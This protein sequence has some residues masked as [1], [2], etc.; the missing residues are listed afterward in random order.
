MRGVAWPA[1]F[2]ACSAALAAAGSPPLRAQAPEPPPEVAPTGNDPVRLPET[3]IGGGAAPTLDPPAP[4][5]Q[6][7]PQTPADAGLPSVY[8]D[9]GTLTTPSLEA[10]R[11]AIN[12]ETGGANIVELPVLLEGKVS[13]LEDVLK[14]T[15]GVWVTSQNGGDDVQLSIRGSGLGNRTF[16][17]GVNGYI[18]GFM[19]AGRVDAGLQNQLVNQLANRYLEVFRG[20]SSLDMGSTVLG[21]V[22]NFVPYTGRSFDKSTFR[23]EDGYDQYRRIWGATGEVFQ[24]GDYF[25]SFDSFDYGGFRDQ[26]VVGNQRF[27][28]NYGYRPNEDVEN[29]TYLFLNNVKQ[30]L[31]GTLPKNIAQANFRLASP[32]NFGVDTD[33]NWRAIR[34]GNKTALALDDDTLV[35]AGFY[36]AYEGLDHLPTPFVGIIDN[37]Y[38]EF[39]LSLKIDRTGELAGRKNVVAAG[40]RYGYL[41]T[42]ANRYRY[43]QN[44]EVPILTQQVYDATERARQFEMYVQ[45]TWSW[46]EDFR[47]VVGLQY[48]HAD[49]ILHD[50]SLTPLP[51]PIPPFPPQP[52]VV[53]GNQS[54]ENPYDQFCPRFGFNA[55]LTET[56]IL[57]G[58]VS[59]SAEAP[60]MSEIGDR[61]NFAQFP[62]FAGNL[63]AQT[64]WT[65]EIG[66][67][68]QPTEGVTLDLAY[69]HSWIRDELLFQQAP[70]PNQTLTINVP[71][72]VHEGVELGA[73]IDVGRGLFTSGPTD[74]SNDLLQWNVVYDWFNFH[75]DA[76]PL[77]GGA[78]LPGVPQNVVYTS[79]DYRHPSGI[80]LGPNL[81]CVGRYDLTFNNTGGDPFQIDG[82][83]LLGFRAGYQPSEKW[84][85]YVDMRNLTDRRYLADGTITPGSIPG[86]FAQVTPGQNRAIYLGVQTTW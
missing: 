78:R 6:N 77:Y 17:R 80:I 57:Y 26:S 48:F 85:F 59:R 21:G 50:R 34:L 74:A 68:G 23:Y 63:Q 5:T 4:A 52:N 70:V 25:A 79:L 84:Y 1:I 41:D 3:V 71:K 27:H 73:L 75:F 30:E 7:F 32:S 83:S 31:P 29:R 56:L 42:A 49:R 53:P 2:A 37:D 12:A 22:I 60:S 72:T 14:T 65:P 19:P 55:D 11:Q 69:Y 64:A 9:G 16:G 47:L 58:N 39:G 62:A 43:A 54:S 18:D 36:G 13:N 8:R 15:P 28:L 46:R 10:A 81:R 20:G 86:G 66:L 40:T 82:Y 51:P 76:D 38:R 35:T 67:R 24:D 45:D 44:G 61:A 33:R